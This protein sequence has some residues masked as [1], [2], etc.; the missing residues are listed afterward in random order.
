MGQYGDAQARSS[1]TSTRQGLTPAEIARLPLER[2]AV[3]PS[4]DPVKA[5]DIDDSGTIRLQKAPEFVPEYFGE[6]GPSE[7]DRVGRLASVGGNE[8][9]PGR[10]TDTVCAI[11]LCDYEVG[12]NLRVLLPCSH[13]FHAR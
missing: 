12:C 10:S 9:G 7:G 2:Y 1:S 13:S 3:M 11:C 4:T 6:M 8:A 5:T